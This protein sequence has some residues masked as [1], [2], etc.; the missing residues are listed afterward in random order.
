M[1]DLLKPDLD[2]TPAY[3]P[4]VPRGMLLPVGGVDPSNQRTFL[5]SALT[6]SNGGYNDSV[7]A[8]DNLVSVH[9]ADNSNPADNVVGQLGNS[10]NQRVA[11][12]DNINRAFAVE[13]DKKENFG[14]CPLRHRK[15]HGF[16]GNVVP[17]LIH[18]ARAAAIIAGDYDRPSLG[19]V[20]PGD[21]L[22]SSKLNNAIVRDHLENPVIE[23]SQP[24]K[25]I[26]AIF[27]QYAYEHP[28]TSN[29]GIHSNVQNTPPE[30]PETTLSDLKE[31][32]GN[33]KNIP[34]VKEES[35]ALNGSL[36]LAIAIIV[37]SL[38]LILYFTHLLNFDNSGMENL[39]KEARYLQS[40]F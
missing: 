21:A 14:P 36:I 29:V 18:A 33:G 9:A 1:T 5:S 26:D 30:E 39:M 3:A 35:S 12:H 16:G 2:I 17:R 15:Q 27:K 40:R 24:E 19:A 11:V 8:V 38:V 34:K 32:P 23:P 6:T 22:G 28:E 13:I 20:P 4:P 31:M 10:V 37:F 25:A 7:K